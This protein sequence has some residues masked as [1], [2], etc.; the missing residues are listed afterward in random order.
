M[1]TIF[2]PTREIIKKIKTHIAWNMYEFA[3]DPFSLRS[4][5]EV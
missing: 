2:M 1:Y 5:P 4:R 3:Q